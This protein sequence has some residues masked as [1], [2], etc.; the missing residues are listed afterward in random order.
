MK[1]GIKHTAGVIEAISQFQDDVVPGA[2]TEITEAKYI[3]FVAKMKSNP[4]QTYDTGTD[5]L[6]QDIPALSAAQVAKQ[7]N[8]LRD[9]LRALSIELDLQTR[10]GES[11]TA[12]QASFDAKKAAYE[13]L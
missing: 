3:A 9:Q 7:K 4:F 5:D 11:T 8:D 1:Y 13:A 10:M 2:F 12:T 6:V